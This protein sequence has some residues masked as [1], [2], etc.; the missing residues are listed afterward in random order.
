MQ[1]LNSILT[2]KA[3][4]HKSN[5][6]LQTIKS[7]KTLLDA[8][9]LKKGKWMLFLTGLISIADVIALAIVV[10]VLMLAIDG[11]FL[12][13]SRKLRYLYRLMG[14]EKESSFLIMLIII[15]VVFFIFKNILAI[16]LQRKIHLLGSKI[17][18]KFTEKSFYHVLS[19]PYEKF[20]NKGSSEFLNKIHFNS[21][22]YSTGVLLP[23][24]HIFGESL[25]ILLMMILIILYNPPIFLLMVC[26][27]APAFYLINKTIKQKIYNLGVEGK[28]QRE[29]TI[30]SLNIGINGLMDIKIN[31]SST[32]FIKDFLSKQKPLVE[33]DLKSIF[34]QNIP[35]RA[36]EI[37]V[38]FA[39]I[40]LV[41]Y[42]FFFSDNPA[43]LRTLAAIF[44][45][46]VFRL[47][48]ALNRL[49][50]GLMK[51]KLYQHTIDFL[52]HDSINNAIAKEHHIS[53]KNNI[54]VEDVAF[55][56]Q[57]TEN[58][59][60]KAV[61]FK[62]GLGETIG[63]IG[64]SGSGKSTLMKV[65][66][67]LVKP[68]HGKVLIDGKELNQDNLYHW[69][70]QVG[71]VHQVPFIFNKTLREN[72]T[73]ETNFDADKL[74]KVIKES[75]L[76]DFVKNLP[77]GLDTL[78]GEQGS[79]ISEGQKQRIAIARALYKD[80][81]LLIFDEATSSLD[82]T[83]ESYIIESLKILKK[84][85]VSIVI[86]AHHGKIIH[87]CDSQYQFEKGELKR[88]Y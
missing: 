61:N 32:F 41:V 70:Q 60:F 35:A 9:D 78:M 84:K 58:P 42:G 49:L 69:L 62:I 21:L 76:D 33:N 4:P 10:P 28:K 5:A 27:T 13:K 57:D 71:F 24:V 26:I 17:V 88:L 86:I 50:V 39:V 1:K 73:L 85:N 12:S 14:S 25:V 6:I 7:I 29:E 68:T 83:T 87:I 52:D 40:C 37:V 77:N 72:I 81:K 16:L 54:Q 80:V 38:L 59:L 65:L 43:G 3:L 23:F 2:K 44:V 63:I 55:Q 30:D 79:K 45:L 36:N 53:F 31:Q 75:C 22:Y 48:P 56:Y 67:G 34:Y 82:E 8:Q 20:S 47:V 66:S 18:Q 11:D 19:Q 15:I 46:A 51:L 64:Q 74:N